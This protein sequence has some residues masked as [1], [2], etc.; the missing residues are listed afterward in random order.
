V[1]KQQHLQDAHMVVTASKVGA[2][3]HSALASPVCLH[4]TIL[5]FLSEPKLVRIHTY[6]W[7]SNFSHWHRC[8]KRRQSITF[9]MNHLT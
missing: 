9:R 3:T 5:I 6:M 4:V 2:C 8:I 1:T 7:S